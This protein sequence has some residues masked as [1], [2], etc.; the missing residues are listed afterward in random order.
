MLC[1][2]QHLDLISSQQLQRRG[3]L[4]CD[5]LS[6]VQNPLERITRFS[7]NLGNRIVKGTRRLE[8]KEQR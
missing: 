3:I 6:V 5:F 1:A 7:G 2:E 4:Q 8:T